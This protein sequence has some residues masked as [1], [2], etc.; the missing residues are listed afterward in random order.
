MQ[1]ALLNQLF[2]S[3]TPPDHCSAS[4]VM[5][6]YCSVGSSQCHASSKKP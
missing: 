4:G 3:P 2:A 1:C 5:K 6:Y